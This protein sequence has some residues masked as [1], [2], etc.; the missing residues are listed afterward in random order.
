TLQPILSPILWTSIATGK[1]GDKHRI[2]SFVQPTPDGGGIRP[3]TSYSRRAKTLW[4]ILSQL[5]RRSVVVNWFASHPA[6]PINGAIVSNRYAQSVLASPTTEENAFHPRDLAEVMAKLRVTAADL[7]PAQMAPFF[8]EK[9]P[10]DDDNR[11][12][13]LAHVVA[14][15]ATVHNAATYLAAAEEWDFLAVYYDMIDHVGHDFA[16]YGPP[17]MEHVSE[18]DFA[19]Y[20]QVMESTYRYHDLMLG[21]WLE[22]IDDNTVVMLLSDHGFYHGAG[23]PL[24]ER[25]RLSG[26]RPKGVH[27]N[28]LIWHRLHGVFVASGPGIK[29]DALVHSASLL[30]VAPTI[31]ATLGLAVPDDF[32]GK[33]LLPI[34][35]NEPDV[36]TCATLEPP[37]PNDGVH[38]EAPMEEQDPWAAQQAVAQL[39]ELGYVDAPEGDTAKQVAMAN[40]SRDSHLAQIY[41][42]TSRFEDALDILRNLAQRSDDPSYAARCAMCLLA[43]A[44]VD[45]ADAILQTVLEKHP[46]YGLAKMLSAQMALLRERTDE[47]EAALRELQQAEAEMPALHTQLGTICVRQQRWSEA[48]D[49][50]RRALEADPDLPEAHDGLGVALRHLGQTEEAIHEH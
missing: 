5:G 21:R 44:R 6:E 38:R 10:A 23:R 43:L 34:F 42:A 49:F 1:R 7:T 25:A 19:V 46:F 39:A 32:E 29:A 47:A 37:H 16:Q 36:K 31:L 18:E 4:N 12:Q 3:V 41:F 30:D 28:P 24:A 48:A 13:K 35:E 11:L 26:E 22:L 33:V 40:E 17:Q 2:L 27:T 9:R 15:C 14:Q 45:E 8:P 50:F 20:S